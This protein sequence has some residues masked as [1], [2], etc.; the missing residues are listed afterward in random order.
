MTSEIIRALPVSPFV[1]KY[2][3]NM[4]RQLRTEFNA[5]LFFSNYFT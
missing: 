5:D 1:G 3:Q 4:L 2:R